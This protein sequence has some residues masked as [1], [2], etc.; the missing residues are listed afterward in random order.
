[1]NLNTF[2][3]FLPAC[4]ALNMVLG[5]NNVL[6]IMIGAEQGLKSAAIAYLG[7]FF[8]FYHFNFHYSVRP[9]HPTH[10]ICTNIFNDQIYWSNLFTLD[11]LPAFD[12]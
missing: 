7:R 6:S 11:W 5:P 12:K 2:L 3:L 9:R 8:C 1:M 4:L 10:S